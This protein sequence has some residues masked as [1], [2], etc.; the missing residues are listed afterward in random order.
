MQLSK[1]YICVMEELLYINIFFKI[2]IPVAERF[3][4]C[5]NTLLSDI[6][7]RNEAVRENIISAQIELLET[8]SQLIYKYKVDGK[9][10]SETSRGVSYKKFTIKILFSMI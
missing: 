2:G 1:P 8:T 3:S 7:A 4:F 5:L 9:G 6:A 10:K